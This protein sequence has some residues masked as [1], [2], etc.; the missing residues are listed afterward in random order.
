M[1]EP[2]LE[3]RL[4]RYRPSGPPPELRARAIAGEPDVRPAWPWAAAAAVLLCA[5]VVLHGARPRADLE[6][7][8]DEALHTAAELQM[9]VEV[10]GDGTN[11]LDEARRLLWEQQLADLVEES[12]RP[13]QR[14][15]QW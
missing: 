10:L 7:T 2:E 13:P 9:L 14:A 12:R 4:R 6:R 3:E 11:A 1:T 5:T 8:G 15:E